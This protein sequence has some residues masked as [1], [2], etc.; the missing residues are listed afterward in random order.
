MEEQYTPRFGSEIIGKLTR[1]TDN[2]L[3][4]SCKKQ[5]TLHVGPDDLA[6]WKQRL[7][8]GST[9]G[10]LFLDEGKIRVRLVEAQSQKPATK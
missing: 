5:Y 10:I 9:L 2:T 6:R 7:R 4:L 1:A 3:T 8:V